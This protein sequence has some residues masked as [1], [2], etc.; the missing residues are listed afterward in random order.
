MIFDSKEKMAG[1]IKWGRYFAPYLLVMG[2]AAL[3][4]S[5]SISGEFVNWDDD[6]FV[7]DNDSVSSLSS[8]NI[9]HAFGGL[10]FES[11]QPLH[12][13]SYMIDGQLWHK[14]A[15]LYRLHNLLLYLL[16]VLLLHRLLVRLKF[17]TWPA[18]LGG[19]FFAVAPYHI[20]SVAWIAC[21]KDVL[22]LVFLLSAWHVHLAA[23]GARYRWLLRS[24]AMLLFVG[25]LLSKSSGLVF[26]AMVFTVD[27][28]VR[29]KSW[30]AALRGIALYLPWALMLGGALPFIWS[31]ASLIREPADASVIGRVMLVGWTFFHYGATI[32]W[33]FRLSPLYAEPSDAALRHGFIFTSIVFAVG[34]AVLLSAWKKG[35]SIW[36]PVGIGLLTLAP[37]LPF[38]NL[39]PMYYLVADRYLLLPS[40]G[41]AMGLSAAIAFAVEKRTQRLLLVIVVPFIIAMSIGAARESAFWRTSETLWQH[42]TQ[43]EPNAYYARLKYGEVLRN[44]GKYAQS[45]RQYRKAKS[46]RPLSPL[47]LGGIFWGA[48]LQDIERTGADVGSNEKLVAHF[49]SI[50]NHGSKLKSFEVQLRKR[51]LEQAA[52]IVEERL[53]Q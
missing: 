7:L 38:L 4:V 16:G 8:D 31:D 33:P 39:V 35:R 27:V 14:Q 5:P 44:L 9:V 48:L 45:V 10:R 37:L 6:R 40:I 26:P 25:A 1:A 32:L 36:K 12:L 43:V 29:G 3:V 28:A 20:E 42:A 19:L 53:G 15:S 17:G 50:A 11:Y 30:K 24:V 22:M 34:I 47:A 41:L 52:S 49:L 21:R 46:I 13:L 18:F 51:G 2:M 23:S